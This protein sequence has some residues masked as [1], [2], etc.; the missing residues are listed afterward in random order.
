MNVARTDQ[1][2]YVKHFSTFFFVSQFAQLYFNEILK[3]I[4]VRWTSKLELKLAD[5][6][7]QSYAVSVFWL[8]LTQSFMNEVS[9]VVQ[10]W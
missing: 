1:T 6:A 3:G 4:P 2:P 9:A 7:T 5:N 8:L 10:H